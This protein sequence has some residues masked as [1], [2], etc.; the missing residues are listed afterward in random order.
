MTQARV[1]LFIKLLQSL[2]KG[3]VPVRTPAF[4]DERGQPLPGSV[5]L[6]ETV[7]IGGLPQRLWFRGVSRN[8]PALVLVHGGP[9]GSLGALFRRYN[10]ELERHFSTLR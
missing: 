8:N 9:G 1:S 10:A 5:A 3:V 6:M 7:T 2:A 4:T